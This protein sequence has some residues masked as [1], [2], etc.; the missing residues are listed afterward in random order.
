MT[1]FLRGSIFSDKVGHKPL[2]LCGYLLH[3]V[4]CAGFALVA[5][6][7]A[8]RQDHNSTRLAGHYR[9]DVPS[10]RQ[11]HG[12]PALEIHCPSAPF[13]FGAIM[14]LLASVLLYRLIELRRAGMG[15]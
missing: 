1:L 14:A 5:S 9:R 7:S 3:A 11:P 10:P 6:Q 2:L 12:R 13:A 15:S 8:V 4:A